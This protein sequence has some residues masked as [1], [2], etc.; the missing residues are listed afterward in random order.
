MDINFG[1]Y[2]EKV[3]KM[4][5]SYKAEREK[6]ITDSQRTFFIIIGILFA[7]Y[8]G[9]VV[10]TCFNFR[11]GT[12]ILIL[13]GIV[14]FGIFMLF[15]FTA[16]DI[17]YK[18]KAFSYS[19][20]N[21]LYIYEINDF[22]FLSLFGLQQYYAPKTVSG[23]NVLFSTIREMSHRENQERL[24]KIVNGNKCV[25]K[26]VAK[27]L[28]YRGGTRIYRIKRMKKHKSYIK[29]DYVTLNSKK[30]ERTQTITIYNNLRSY[31]GWVDFFENYMQKTR[32][33]CKNCGAI[34]NN[35]RCPKCF[36]TEAKKEYG[37]FKFLCNIVLALFIVGA[38]FLMI[39]LCAMWIG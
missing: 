29:M 20:K 27:D 34:M 15:A 28:E 19:S 38:T 10:W 7:I 33:V 31:E 16:E 30:K 12:W 35:G 9:F 24:I 36:C 11:E 21:G 23:N 6:L 14:I 39:Y 17:N 22:N 1:Y 5:T 13:F 37:V 32:Y 18:T 3:T 2:K 8:F 4:A 26:L 25:E